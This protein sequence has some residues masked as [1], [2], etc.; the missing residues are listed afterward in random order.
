MLR[1]ILR[2]ILTN[3]ARSRQNCHRIKGV[4]KNDFKLKKIKAK[5]FS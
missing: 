5:E 1:L 2:R 3:A 4:L